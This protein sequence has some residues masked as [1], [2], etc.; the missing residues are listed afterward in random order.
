MVAETDGEVMHAIGGSE[1]NE[2]V[3]LLKV[4][5]SVVVLPF[6]KHRNISCHVVSE[7]NLRI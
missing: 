3:V 1:A 5:S 7:S 2:I 6:S 4:E